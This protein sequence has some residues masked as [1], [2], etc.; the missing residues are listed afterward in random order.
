MVT[1]NNGNDNNQSPAEV[2]DFTNFDGVELNTLLDRARDWLNKASPL[3]QA[4]MTIAQQASLMRSNIPFNCSPEDR[5]EYER[6]IQ[7]RPEQIILKRLLELEQKLRT[8]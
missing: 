4:K 5:A 6:Q 1:N 2:V 3:D 7:N 8:N